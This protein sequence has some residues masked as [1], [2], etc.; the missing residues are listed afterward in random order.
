L[1]GTALVVSASAAFSFQMLFSYPKSALP[2]IV[3]GC[4]GARLAAP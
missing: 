1:E 3:L 4:P 2:D